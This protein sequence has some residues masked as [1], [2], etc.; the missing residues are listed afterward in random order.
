MIFSELV[1][2]RVALLPLEIA[3]I[4]PLYE[5]SRN[6]EIWT[7]YPRVI[8]SIQEMES[9]VVKA[10][11]GRDCGEEYPFAVLDKESNRIVGTTRY[12]RISEQNRNLNIGSTWYTPEVWRSR[13]NTECKYLLLQYAFEQ[14]SAV[15]VE[16]ITTPDNIR[17]QRA[18][19]RLGAV[20]EGM[21]RKKYNRRNYV[22]YSVID[23]EWLDVK[24]RLE[25]LLSY[26]R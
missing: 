12:L 6:P 10:L 16:L 24:G 9:F 2:E 4:E 21:F 3:H 18:I 11:Y 17:S 23:D 5:C 19:E 25:G 22:V 20:R 26:R 14:W 13:V 1:G 15:R 8:S 7:Y